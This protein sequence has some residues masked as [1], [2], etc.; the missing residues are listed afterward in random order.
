VHVVAKGE[1]LWSIAE[2]RL[3]DGNRYREIEALNPEVRGRPLAVGQQLRL[4]DGSAPV[5]RANSG[6]SEAPAPRTQPKPATKPVR[7]VR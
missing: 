5:A 3:G 1:N 7:R 6:A 4:P 2:R